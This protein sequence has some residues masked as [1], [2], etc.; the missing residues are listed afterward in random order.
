MGKRLRE[1]ALPLRSHRAGATSIEY[2]LIG[3]FISILIVG[4]A[5][6]IGNSVTN[7]FTQVANGF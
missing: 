2:A 3:A 4:W 5:T 6:A 7:F 1:I